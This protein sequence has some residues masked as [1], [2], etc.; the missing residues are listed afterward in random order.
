M[1][2]LVQENPQAAIAYSWCDRID[3][4]SQFLREGRHFSANG[5]IYPRLLLT[6][7]LENG[8][9]PSIRR[10]AF[11]K[12]GGF[13]ESVQAMQDRDLYLHL[14]AHYSFVAVPRV[15]I[16]YRVSKVSLSS[17]NFVSVF[18]KAISTK[19]Y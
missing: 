4:S 5:N 16:F 3:E 15:Q 13:D 8:S 10:D 6:N 19:F 2:R 17:C 7:I 9:N 12:V 18:Y 11:T 1:K 14:A